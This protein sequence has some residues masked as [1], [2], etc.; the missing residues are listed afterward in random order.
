MTVRRPT[1]LT[2]E[3]E[4]LLA[5]RPAALAA[6]IRRVVSD[7]RPC[8]RVTSSRTTGVPA[9]GS[10]VGRLLGRP[11]PEPLLLPTASK[12][13][14]VPYVE[15]ALDLK[16]AKFIGQINFAEVSRALA[17]QEFPRP[18]GMPESGVLSVDL[19]QGFDSGARVRWYPDAC[20]ARAVRPTDL[21]TVARYEAAMQFFGSWSM[22]GLEWF[23]AVPEDDGELWDFMND[24]EVAGVDEDGHGGHKLL[25]HPNEALNEHYG[26]GP[27]DGRSANI[28]DY[29]LLWRIDYDNAAGFSWGTNWL[30]VVIHADDLEKGALQNAFI[31]GANA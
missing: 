16:G 8:V 2:P 9:R 7:L 4:R 31:T 28:R 26:L 29:S 12:F 30:Y 1:T 3:L 13:G 17:E 24:L 19:P 18:K 6:E 21:A 5:S 22:R 14:G 15:H 23:D 10:F 20:E 11:V 25:G 27:A